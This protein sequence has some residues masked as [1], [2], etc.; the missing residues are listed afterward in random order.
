[1]IQRIR[2]GR[3]WGAQTQLPEGH[4]Y[5]A[6]CLRGALMTATDLLIVGAGTAGSALAGFAAQAGLSVTCLE[7]RALHRAGARWVNGVLARQFSEAGVAQPTGAELRG[8]GH[9]FHLVAGYGP[10]KISIHDHEV[11]DVDMRLLV[12]RLQKVALEAGARFDEGVH[13]QSWDGSTLHTSKGAYSAR[14]VVDASGVAGL[15]LLGRERPEPG[16]LC[17]AAQEV[18]EV[19]DEVRAREYFEQQG[20]A[21]GETLCFSGIAGGFSI[22]NLRLDG[23]GVSLLA[24]SIPGSGHPTGQAL[25]DDLARKEPWIGPKIFGGARAIPLWRPRV[26]LTQGRLA[27]LGD[28]AGQVFAAH[29]SGIGAGMVAARVLAS[30]LAKAPADLGAYAKTWYRR[31]GGPVLA[32]DLLRRFS[33]TLTVQ[34]I[35]TLMDSGVMN[36]ASA[37]A[38]LEQRLPNFRDSRRQR[39]GLRA[40]ATHPRLFARAGSMLS[41]V[42]LCMLAAR[43]YPTG[44]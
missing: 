30:T 43:A 35:E 26:Q 12:E 13:V 29:G 2:R 27:L 42:P 17:V 37:R 18:R 8:D 44:F 36:E 16:D 10:R 20:A 32:A 15:G 1:M 11:A 5:D 28:S 25:I 21:P 19:K 4:V 41:K 23:E 24:G 40:I 33:E 31:Y 22:L 38:T 39:L 9:T 14:Y 7:R 6:L 3:S 34:D